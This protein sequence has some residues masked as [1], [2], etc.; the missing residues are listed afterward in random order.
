MKYLL[1]RDVSGALAW[2]IQLNTSSVRLSVT[3]TA[4]LESIIEWLVFKFC[5]CFCT[6]VGFS[7]LYIDNLFYTGLLLFKNIHNTGFNCRFI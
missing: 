2:Y 5:H 6:C 4:T 1:K 7:M 3:A